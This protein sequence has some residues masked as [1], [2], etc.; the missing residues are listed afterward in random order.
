MSE[1]VLELLVEEV[2]QAAA[3]AYEI[4]EVD[5]SG[6]VLTPEELVITE[7]GNWCQWLTL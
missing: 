3:A 4:C 6:L 1:C 5:P 2:E 7:E